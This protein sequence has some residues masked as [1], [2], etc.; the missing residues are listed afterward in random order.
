MFEQ[1]AA[2]R[3]WSP[4]SEMHRIQDE[5]NRLFSSGSRRFAVRRFPSLN[6][7]LNQDEAGVTSELP[8]CRAKI[9]KSPLSGIG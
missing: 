3:L 6:V 5:F 2:T 9:W 1:S 8:V 7:W 4:F